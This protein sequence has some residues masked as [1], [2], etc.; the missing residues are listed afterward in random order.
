MVPSY[1][2][3]RDIFLN[4]KKQLLM[5]E[6]E[7]LQTMVLDRPL[8][9]FVFAAL[10]IVNISVLFA[11]FGV[12]ISVIFFVKSSS[13]YILFFIVFYCLTLENKLE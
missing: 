1:E 3:M 6:V 7:R 13:S 5:E 10:F 8:N 11:V 4:E 2:E 12:L 9:S